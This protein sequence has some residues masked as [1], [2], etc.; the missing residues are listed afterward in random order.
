MILAVA[1]LSPVISPEVKLSN[2]KIF[3]KISPETIGLDIFALSAY[4]MFC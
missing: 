3:V 2:K 1:I 4:N